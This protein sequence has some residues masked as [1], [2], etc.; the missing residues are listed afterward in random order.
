[1]GSQGN[2]S[3]R[4]YQAALT[5]VNHNNSQDDQSRVAPMEGFYYF[6]NIDTRAQAFDLVTIP[7]ALVTVTRRFWR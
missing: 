6:W 3:P 4:R 2:R 1:M 5:P 7:L